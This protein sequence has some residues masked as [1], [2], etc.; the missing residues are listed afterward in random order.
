MERSGK[1]IAV[2]PQH[3]TPNSRSSPSTTKKTRTQN[4][5][6]S[7]LLSSDDNI[8]DNNMEGDDEMGGT[9]GEEEV[10]VEEDESDEAFQDVHEFLFEKDIVMPTDAEVVGTFIR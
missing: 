5:S 2:Q 1:G 7:E 6:L 4:K 9:D 8:H 3:G 10:G